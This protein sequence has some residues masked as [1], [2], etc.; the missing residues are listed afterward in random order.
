MLTVF[1][2]KSVSFI[3]IYY[4][5]FYGGSR[6][7]NV[8]KGNSTSDIITSEN[9]LDK[10]NL[11]LPSISTIKS[12]LPDLSF[13]KLADNDLKNVVKAMAM[14]NIS[15]KIIISYDEIEIRGGL[16]VMKSTGKVTKNYRILFCGCF[17]WSCFVWLS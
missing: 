6:L 9:A 13:G 5:D 8:L 11:L 1:D 17:G 10:L 16:C 3:G 7:W 14:N 4:F 2:T 12:Y 15:N